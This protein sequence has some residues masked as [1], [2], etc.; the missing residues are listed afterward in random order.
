MSAPGEA[1]P[2]QA[3]QGRRRAIPS[4]PTRGRTQGTRGEVAEG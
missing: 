4:R 2:S 3:P 1:M